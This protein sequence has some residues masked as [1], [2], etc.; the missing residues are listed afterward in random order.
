LNGR[1]HRETNLDQGQAIDHW[2][3]LLAEV[4]MTRRQ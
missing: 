4:L 3:S 2:D 1:R